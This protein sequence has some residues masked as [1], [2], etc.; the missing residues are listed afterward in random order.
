MDDKTTQ[1][2]ASSHYTLVKFDCISIHLL[3]VL[4]SS[5][6]NEILRVKNCSLFSSFKS[7]LIVLNLRIH[8]GLLIRLFFFCQSQLSLGRLNQF[9]YNM[10]QKWAKSGLEG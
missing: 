2:Y 7:H 6:V 3:Q 5:L 8:T 4:H 10:S 1:S 9:A